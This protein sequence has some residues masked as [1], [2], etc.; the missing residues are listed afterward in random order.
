MKLLALACVAPLLF[1]ITASCTSSTNGLDTISCSTAMDCVNAVGPSQQ[2]YRWTCK[3]GG[4]CSQCTDDADCVA[5]DPLQPL[6][7]VRDQN[8]APN[9]CNECRTDNDC[10]ARIA[11]GKS[12]APF[13]HCVANYCASCATDADCPGDH[14]VCL[15][16]AGGAECRECR[17]DSDCKDPALPYCTPLGNGYCGACRD[18][19]SDCKDPAKPECKPG[20][21]FPYRAE[22]EAPQPYDPDAGTH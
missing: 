1:V 4:V 3:S 10:A 5:T 2:P 19:A 16:S 21:A 12:A 22:C 18:Y 13:T 14:A 8:D 6:C 17:A 7:V 15:T 9:T 11:T 20:A